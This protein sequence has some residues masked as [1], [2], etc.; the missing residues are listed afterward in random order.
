MSRPPSRNPFPHALLGGLFLWA[1]GEGYLYIQNLGWRYEEWI[2]MPYMLGLIAALLL[3]KST[4]IIIFFVIPQI[5]RYIIIFRPTTRAGSA[6]WASP[7]YLKKKF[8]SRKGFLAG[9]IKKNVPLFIDFESSLLVLAPAGVGKTV[10]FVIPA[11][12]HN[13]MNM[14]VCDLKGTLAVMTGKLRSKVFRHKV[15]YLDPAGKYRNIIGKSSSYNLLQILIDDW[16][17]PRKHEFLFDDAEAIALQLYAEPPNGGENQYWRSGARKFMV[18]AFIYLVTRTQ[19]A[20]LSK[21][22]ALLSDLDRLITALNETKAL[23]ILEGDLANLARDILKKTENGD[24]KQIESFREGAVQALGVFRASGSL[25]KCTEKCDFRFADLKKKQKGLFRRKKGM[26]IYLL[27]DPARINVY[28]PWLGLTMWC[29][30][31]EITR[32][33]QGE[34]V[35]M[36]GDEI[37]NFKIVG[38][39]SFLTL[40]REFG[41]RMVLILQEL[42]EW[43][44]IYGRESLQ[45]LLSQTEAKIIMG[46]GGGDS[47]KIISDMLGEETVKAKNYNLGKSFFEPVTRSVSE[48][49]RRLKTPDEVRRTEEH[50]V[51]QGKE[52]PMRLIPVGYHEVSPWK[53]QVGINPLYGKKFKGKTKLKL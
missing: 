23:T 44:N 40:L 6:G 33:P 17:D 32:A 46:V 14:I 48:T 31:T 9:L 3:L 2:F 16:A 50:I 37:C 25:A 51:I 45:T 7:K 49:S 42:Q 15:L 52:R 8:K 34:P 24:P 53:H 26:T 18:F 5:I 41:V 30:L 13:P 43:A 21:A 12:C 36:L 35:C 47:A 10:R 38:L 11:L 39:P 19:G 4:L 1:A 28:K 22:L 27:A 29:A 20:T